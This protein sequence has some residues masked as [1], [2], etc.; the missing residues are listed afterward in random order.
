M[1]SPPKMVYKHP[2]TPMATT[3]TTMDCMAEIW[4]VSIMLKIPPIPIAP[5]Y[6]TV[7]SK[8]ST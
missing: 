8:I 5:E 1:R 7:G 2:K 6:N 4:K 3:T